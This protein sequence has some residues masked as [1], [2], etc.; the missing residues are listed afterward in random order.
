MKFNVSHSKIINNLGN[1]G[2]EAENAIHLKEAAR[3]MQ[4][5]GCEVKEVTRFNIV[6]EAA[7][8]VVRKLFHIEEHMAK[9]FI[10][11]I[12]NRAEQ[13]EDFIDHIEIPD[14]DGDGIPN[15][16]DPD[17]WREKIKRHDHDKDGVP[18]IVDP[19]WY[20][21]KLFGKKYDNDHGY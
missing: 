8:D 14:H 13:L 21:D 11:A 7:A 10:G 16:I 20:L 4:E 17:W 5:A 15:I 19:D 1:A 3:R 18:N 6:V 2:R 12:K 9:G